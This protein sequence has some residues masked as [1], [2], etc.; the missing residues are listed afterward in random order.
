MTKYISFIIVFILLLQSLLIAQNNT[1]LYCDGINTIMITDDY[2]EFKFGSV[3]GGGQIERKND[4]IIIRNDL[5]YTGQTKSF[6]SFMNYDHKFKKNKVSFIIKDVNNQDVSSKDFVIS[7]TG[8]N[9]PTKI[10]HEADGHYW[11]ELNRITPDMRIWVDTYMYYPMKINAE[12]ISHGI[13]NITLVPSSDW[14]LYMRSVTGEEIYCVCQN[15]YNLI[16]KRKI[17]MSE[18]KYEIETYKLVLCE[19]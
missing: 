9:F 1:I 7:L 8:K 17:R 6:F 15:D 12:S 18:K 11:F 4:T 16:C 19:K 2:A 10:A 3:I 13:Y 14:L 5:Y